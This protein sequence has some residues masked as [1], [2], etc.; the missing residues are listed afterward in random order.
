MN[1]MT[2]TP[3]DSPNPLDQIDTAR[4]NRE[5]SVQPTT[6]NTTNKAQHNETGCDSAEERR[7]NQQIPEIT[8]TFAHRI[9]HT[10]VAALSETN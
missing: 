2:R 3:P 6:L 8:R 9:E 1:A 10:V 7:H 4:L 5:G